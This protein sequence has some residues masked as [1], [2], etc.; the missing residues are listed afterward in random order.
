[1]LACKNGTERTNR[2]RW[3]TECGLWEYLDENAEWPKIFRQSVEVQHEPVAPSLKQRFGDWIDVR[4]A[5]GIETYGGPLTTD[6][7][8]DAR[9]GYAF[10]EI[11]D[12]CQYQEQDRHGTASG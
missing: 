11:L 10:E 7:G 4:T 8:R 5:Q 6:N 9:T 2:S 3:R 12:F 1:M